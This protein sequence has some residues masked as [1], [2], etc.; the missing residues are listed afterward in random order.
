MTRRSRFLGQAV[1]PEAHAFNNFVEAK[2]S[3]RRTVGI[4][5]LSVKARIVQKL[6]FEFRLAFHIHRPDPLRFKSPRG[7]LNVEDFRMAGDKRRAAELELSG[8]G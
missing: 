7:M 1:P 5:G 3:V 6:W 2:K 4:Q 8:S